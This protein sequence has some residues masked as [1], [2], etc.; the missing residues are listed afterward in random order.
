[1]G[2]V[3]QDASVTS[4]P[5]EAVERVYREQ[6][7][8]LYRSLYAFCGDGELAADAMAEALAQALARG[9]GIREPDRWVWRAAFRIAAGELKLRGEAR[10]GY[11]PE[12]GYDMADPTIDLVRALSRLSPNQR[13]AAVLHLYADL[14][15]RDVAKILG[16][17]PA[18]VRVHLT[19][20]RRRL[21]GM[22]EERDD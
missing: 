13:A 5:S 17:A 18:T 7:A 12:R 4:D 21:R 9:E 15:T 19:Q 22:L 3:L 20:A 11:L 16:M 6:G 8:K 1:M 2:V 14:S 10:S